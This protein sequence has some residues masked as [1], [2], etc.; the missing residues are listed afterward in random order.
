M[1]QILDDELIGM[2]MVTTYKAWL[3]NLRLSSLTLFQTNFGFNNFG[4]KVF[5]EPFEKM[6]RILIAI[7][8][9][10]HSVLKLVSEKP[11][12]CANLMHH[13][14]MLSNSTNLKFSCFVK[15]VTLRQLTPHILSKCDHG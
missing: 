1:L 6:T 3:V 10:F 8:F 4:I 15:R 7:F 11:I 5:L 12:N 13:V 2:I 9:F 14:P